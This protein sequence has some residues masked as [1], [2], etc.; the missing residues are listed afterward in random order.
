M[1]RAEAQDTGYKKA[2]VNSTEYEDVTAS[3]NDL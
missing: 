2:I 3:Q 1:V